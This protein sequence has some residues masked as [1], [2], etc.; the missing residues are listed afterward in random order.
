MSITINLT[1][2]TRVTTTKTAWVIEKKKPNGTWEWTKNYT[3]LESLLKNY[4]DHLVINSRSDDLETAVK[5]CNDILLNA[6][7]SHKELL[8]E[9]ITTAT[10]ITKNQ[11]SNNNKNGVRIR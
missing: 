3:S 7:K 5:K 6:M 4:L 10:P 9:M 1:S 11:S 8:T 2:N